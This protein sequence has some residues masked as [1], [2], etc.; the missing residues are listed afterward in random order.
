MQ[1]VSK[2]M[3]GILGRP[4]RPFPFNTAGDY[5][6]TVTDANGCEGSAQITM[7]QNDA[8]I[9]VISGETQICLGENNVLDA[10][11][12]CFL[13][14]EYGRSHPVYHHQYRRRLQRYCHRSE[15][16]RW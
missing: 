10:G 1:E 8:P 5:S 6:V 4:H 3:N 9:V 12:F 16:M 14:L 11:V 15:W 13:S 2:G 7:V